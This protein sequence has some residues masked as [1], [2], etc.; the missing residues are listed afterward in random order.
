MAQFFA[1]ASAISNAVHS[2]TNSFV[3]VGML[4]SLKSTK[5]IHIPLLRFCK[6]EVVSSVDPSIRS[7]EGTSQPAV[8]LLS[9]SLLQLD[10][11]MA[12]D[13][14]SRFGYHLFQSSQATSCCS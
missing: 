8:G 5:R 14:R 1:F 9:V 3:T 6:F 2:Q 11:S 7:T 4:L 10:G 12:M 13:Q